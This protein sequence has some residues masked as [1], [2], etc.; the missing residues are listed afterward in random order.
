MQVRKAVEEILANATYRENIARLGKEFDGYHPN[1]LFA[2]YTLD[3]LQKAGRIFYS[4][5]EEEKIY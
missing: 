5:K 2:Y 4:R 1:E 3:T